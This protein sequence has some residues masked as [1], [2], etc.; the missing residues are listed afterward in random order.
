MIYTGIDLVRTERW[1]KL[2][3]KRPSQAE[4]IFLPEE[5]A[6]CEAKGTHKYESYAALWAV[7]EAA[8]KALGIG[9]FGSSWK[10]AY[11]TWTNWGAPVLHLA[12]TFAAR[13]A[14]LGVTDMSVSVSH[15]GGIAAAV[16][17]MQGGSHDTSGNE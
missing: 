11:L 15:D 6:H 4:R 17:V 5:I 3:T 14:A 12:G 10:D 9:I 13:A 8:G 1:E 7:R 16:V 2:L